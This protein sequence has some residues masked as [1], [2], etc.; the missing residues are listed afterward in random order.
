[1]MRKYVYECVDVKVG[2]FLILN[3]FCL[4]SDTVKLSSNTLQIMQVVFWPCYIFMIPVGF[5]SMWWYIK[6]LAGKSREVEMRRD[7]SSCGMGLEYVGRLASIVSSWC[8][9]W[10]LSASG[11]YKYFSDTGIKFVGFGCEL[12]W[13]CQGSELLQLVLHERLFISKHLELW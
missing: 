9:S 5:G 12:W 1:M 7:D 4:A 8:L 13:K 6:G 3:N 2:I 11:W 10:V